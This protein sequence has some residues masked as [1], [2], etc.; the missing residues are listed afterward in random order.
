MSKQAGRK[1]KR[2]MEVRGREVL[3]LRRL[4]SVLY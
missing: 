1:R 4:A 3:A 2:E